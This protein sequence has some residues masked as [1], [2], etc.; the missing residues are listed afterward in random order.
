[1]SISNDDLWELLLLIRAEL[2]VAQS[3]LAILEAEIK[4]QNAIQRW[5]FAVLSEMN[6]FFS[7][8]IEEM[9]PHTT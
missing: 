7:Q 2:Q 3:T 6:P 1:M 5:Y 4:R 9:R 8:R